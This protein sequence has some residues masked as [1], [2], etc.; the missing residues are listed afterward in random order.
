[1]TVKVDTRV[2]F[3]IKPLLW[4]M[5]EGICINDK[6]SHIYHLYQIV[7]KIGP[8]VEKPFFL[9]S[10]FI[11]AYAKGQLFTP[12]AIESYKVNVMNTSNTLN[13]ASAHSDYALSLCRVKNNVFFLF[14]YMQ[15]FSNKRGLRV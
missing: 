5:K 3:P 4:P 15:I 8:K 7:N 6:L 10:F 13:L 9:I 12:I 1:M 2:L 11:E 14:P